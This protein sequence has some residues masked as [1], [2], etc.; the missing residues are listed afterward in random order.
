MLKDV[1]ENRFIIMR[2]GDMAQQVKVLAAKT[3]DLSSV[4]GIHTEEGENQVLH[5][6]L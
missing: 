6:V 5:I 2:V 3:G 4:P 1:K